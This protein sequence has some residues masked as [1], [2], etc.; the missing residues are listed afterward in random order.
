MARRYDLAISEPVAEQLSA[1]VQRIVQGYT[2]DEPA[3]ELGVLMGNDAPEDVPDDVLVSSDR[4]C[5][6]SSAPSAL[7]ASTG[8]RLIVTR[9]T[10]SWLGS[11][12]LG[13]PVLYPGCSRCARHARHVQ[14]R[15]PAQVGCCASESGPVAWAARSDHVGEA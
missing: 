10:K 13:L 6:T 9:L 4:G 3:I 5:S 2:F 12:R 7:I 11:W 15:Y 1:D 14:R 8:K